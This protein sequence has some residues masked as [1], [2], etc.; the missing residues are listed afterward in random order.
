MAHLQARA[1]L[2]ENTTVPDAPTTT[3][4]EDD[5]DNGDNSSNDI[6]IGLGVGVPLGVIALAA[7]AWAL[8]E[9][10][11][12][13]SRTSLPN[14]RPVYELPKTPEQHQY[15]E[16]Q[17]AQQNGPSGYGEVAELADPGSVARP[18]NNVPSA[19]GISQGPWMLHNE[20]N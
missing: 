17:Y 16:Q 11:K 6:R 5:R 20:H 4:D 13:K 2:R 18:R 14:C 7:I 1:V 3:E 10:R 15:L 9:R 12:A 19:A 8:Y